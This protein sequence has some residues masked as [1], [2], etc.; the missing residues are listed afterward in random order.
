M[1]KDLDAMHGWLIERISAALK[2]KG[3]MDPGRALVEIR[4]A[5]YR[6]RHSGDGN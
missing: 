1:A 6:R 3:V 4:L 5:I 2:I